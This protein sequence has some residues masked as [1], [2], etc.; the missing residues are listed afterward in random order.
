MG[1]WF[2]DYHQ[3][4]EF[5]LLAVTMLLGILALCGALACG[6]RIGCRSLVRRASEG[7]AMYRRR[8]P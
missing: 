2:L 3:V 4:L 6:L 8:T 5:R 7:M 1:D